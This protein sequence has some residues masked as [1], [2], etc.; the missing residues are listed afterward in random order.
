MTLEHRR[1]SRLGPSSRCSSGLASLSDARL[2]LR[3]A[4]QRA[5]A[6]DEIAAGDPDDLASRE[7]SGES[8][9][10]DS[11]VCIV[12]CGDDDDFVGDVEIRVTGGEA[13]AIEVD[14]R[15]HRERFYAERIAVLIAHIF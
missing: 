10:S 2:L 7:E 1:P 6:E 11:I 5:E 14:R 13:L 3:H 15:G 4:V 12:E 8:I 9:E